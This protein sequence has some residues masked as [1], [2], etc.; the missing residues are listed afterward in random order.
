MECLAVAVVWGSEFSGGTVRSGSLPFSWAWGRPRA[1]FCCGVF[2]GRVSVCAGEALG[3]PPGNPRPAWEP[4]WEP[5]SREVGVG[6]PP[7]KREREKRSPTVTSA[8]P[9]VPK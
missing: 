1:R 7:E 9:P 5:P 6:K 4:P 2:V 3:E 8:G